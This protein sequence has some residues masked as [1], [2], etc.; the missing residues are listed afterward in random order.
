MRL[1]AYRHPAGFELALPED[2]ERHEGAMGAALIAREPERG[3][4]FRANV[5]VTVEAL[6]R[7]LDLRGWTEQSGAALERA[8]QHVHVV[9]DE[10]VEVGGVPARRRLLLHRSATEGGIALEQW[11]LVADG[12]GY[13]LS[14]STAAL[15]YDDLAD[16]CGGVARSFR[17]V[18][19]E[20]GVSDAPP[21]R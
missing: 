9:D 5:V 16:L 17:P 7:G 2:W 21:G 12:R 3:P 8:L 15:E 14:A 4:S 13:V 19:P 20:D 10:D 11:S 1:A 18:S 6:S